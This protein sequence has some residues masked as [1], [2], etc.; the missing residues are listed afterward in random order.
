M[1]GD[2]LTDL[3]INNFLTFHNEHNP[4]SSLITYP[5]KAFMVF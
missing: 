5:L 1:N 2:E 3:P 4:I